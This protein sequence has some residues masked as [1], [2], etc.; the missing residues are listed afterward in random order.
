MWLVLE[1][2]LCV[3][4]LGGILSAWWIWSL[5]SLR[6]IDIIQISINVA[7]FDQLRPRHA[8][9]SVR[10]SLV[11]TFITFVELMACFGL[12]YLT[13][14]SALSGATAWSDAFYFSAITQL[15]IGYGDIH[16]IGVMRFLAAAQGVAGVTLIVISFGRVVGTFTRFTEIFSP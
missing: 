3:G 14:L 13:H 7:V 4:Y 5:A 10:R 15:T 6:V 8:I 12:L 11:L 9:T 16:P 2:A 1:A